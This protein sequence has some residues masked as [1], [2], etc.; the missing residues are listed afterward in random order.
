M[1]LVPVCLLPRELSKFQLE[2]RAVVWRQRRGR[3]RSR[4][5][6]RG[7]GG[8]GG[9]LLLLY[10][11]RDSNRDQ[12]RQLLH[13]RLIKHVED[14]CSLCTLVSCEPPIVSLPTWQHVITCSF[15]SCER[16]HDFL[17]RCAVQSQAWSRSEL[18]ES[19]FYRSYYYPSA[20]DGVHLFF[21]SSGLDK[22]LLDS[23]AEPLL[24]RAGWK[25]T[26]GSEH[27]CPYTINL[28]IPAAH[29]SR[30]ETQQNFPPKSPGKVSEFHQ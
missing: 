1:P 27:G 14:V 30:L 10:R 9:G 11:R 3:G 18:S 16:Y 5:C 2:L 21:Y 22:L 23:Q 28:F 8:C 15:S 19:L 13:L 26:K 20:L 7:S 25:E 12:L 4:C 24:D 17:L 29:D 6:G